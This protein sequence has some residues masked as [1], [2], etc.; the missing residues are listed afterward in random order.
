[1]SPKILILNVISGFVAMNVVANTA[2]GT[3]RVH[4]YHKVHMFS[5]GRYSPRAKMA[6]NVRVEYRQQVAR[7][8][9]RNL[10]DA[11]WHWSCLWAGVVP[12]TPGAGRWVNGKIGHTERKPL[13]KYRKSEST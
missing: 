6:L 7:S 5:T 1:M 3:L 13:F 10:N 12:F 9:F 8:C 11:G 4:L 2:R